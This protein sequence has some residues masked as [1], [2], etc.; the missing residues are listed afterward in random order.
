MTTRDD[1][2]RRQPMQTR[3]VGIVS[4]PSRGRYLRVMTRK[5]VKPVSARSENQTYC[6]QPSSIC[7]PVSRARK[8]WARATFQRLASTMTMS[9]IAS[10]QGMWATAATALGWTKCKR[11]K[12]ENVK[13]R[14]PTMAASCRRSRRR[15]KKYIPASISG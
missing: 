14:L 12:L 10:S 15:S 2:F 3:Q 6:G 1:E 8:A 5:S 13:A 7:D 11:L 4:Q 9:I